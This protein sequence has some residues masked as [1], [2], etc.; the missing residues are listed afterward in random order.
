MRGKEGTNGW[1]NGFVSDDAIL[2]G[3]RRKG[4][5]S[6]SSSSMWMHAGWMEGGWRSALMALFAPFMIASIT[7]GEEEE[8]TRSGSERIVPWAK[9]G[10]VPR[11]R[12]Q[13]RCP[14]Y[15]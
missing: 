5:C 14:I 8:A 15:C 10:C 6:S 1:L 13:A 11:C 7:E 2:S 12:K 9:Y 3:K 4:V